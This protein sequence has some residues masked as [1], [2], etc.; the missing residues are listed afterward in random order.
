MGT[1]RSGEGV[2]PDRAQQ[3]VRRGQFRL[4]QGDADKGD[5]Q[6]RRGAEH[7]AAAASCV[8]AIGAARRQA[9]NP[10]RTGAAF[11]GDQVRGRV[12]DVGWPPQPKAGPGPDRAAA[13][14][15]GNP[16]NSSTDVCPPKGR[17]HRRSVAWR[18]S[19]RNDEIPAA[20]RHRSEAQGAVTVGHLADRHQVGRGA[21]VIDILAAMPGFTH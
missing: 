16:G 10:Q 18:R 15:S 14:R 20:R 19:G 7:Q 1:G 12:P 13:P 4:A 2:A 3:R 6:V 17:A 9:R 11:K 8:P 5:F 21:Q